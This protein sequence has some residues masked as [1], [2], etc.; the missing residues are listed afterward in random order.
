MEDSKLEKYLLLSIEKIKDSG[1]TNED[2]AYSF[3]KQIFCPN[4]NYQKPN[5]EISEIDRY[6]KKVIENLNKEGFKNRK[7]AEAFHGFLRENGKEVKAPE[8]KSPKA[9]KRWAFL[10]Y[11]LSIIIG[12]I[13]SFLMILA[14]NLGINMFGFIAKEPY[15]MLMV[16]GCINAVLSNLIFLGF[17]ANSNIWARIFLISAFVSGAAFAM[18]KIANSYRDIFMSS[19]NI[20]SA[21]NLLELNATTSPVLLV[22]IITFSYLIVSLL[23]EM[24]KR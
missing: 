9:K 1:F 17:K 5:K 2:I 14:D 16:I 12:I 4:G 18:Q 24:R 6:F 21:F 20:S 23:F 11:F 15:I 10:P 7:I 22:F 3:N 8:E 13:F 19:F